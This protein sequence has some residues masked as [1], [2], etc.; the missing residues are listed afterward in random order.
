MGHPRALPDGV[1]ELQ[2]TRAGPAPPVA[3]ALPLPRPE[4]DVSAGRRP[5]QSDRRRLAGAGQADVLLRRLRA[6]PPLPAGLL[7]AGPFRQFGPIL[8]DIGPELPGP[9][10][11]R[12][13]AV[14]ERHVRAPEPGGAGR[15]EVRRGGVPRGV[16]VI[17]EVEDAGVSGPEAGGVR[18]RVRCP[19]C[20]PA[21][22]S[23]T[24]AQLDPEEERGSAARLE[25]GK[26]GVLRVLARPLARRVL[27]GPLGRPA[28]NLM[29]KKIITTKMI[30][31]TL[32][33]M[34]R[35][36]M[37][38]WRFVLSNTIKSTNNRK[39]CNKVNSQLSGEN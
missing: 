2:A 29:L 31:W 27:V 36:M 1:G 6:D 23:M 35:F 10:V 34:M 5:E 12:G 32:K 39:L 8:Q 7:L 16:S 37:M 14:R 30:L 13:R 38:I 17:S 18:G 26:L 28:R 22:W 24:A 33:M 15:L 25:S 3:R 19:F 4:D 20:G 21:L 11:Q 9:E